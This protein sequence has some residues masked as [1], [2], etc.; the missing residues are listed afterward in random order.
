[1]KTCHPHNAERVSTWSEDALLQNS[2]RAQKI[3][4]FLPKKRKYLPQ[5]SRTL[6]CPGTF[7]RRLLRLCFL[8]KMRNAKSNYVLLPFFLF[9][10]RW[11]LLLTLYSVHIFL[12]WIKMFSVKLG[13]SNHF[14]LLLVAAAVIVKTGITSIA[15]TKLVMVVITTV[16]WTD[17]EIHWTIAKQYIKAK[18]GLGSA[19]DKAYVAFLSPC[20]VRTQAQP[21]LAVYVRACVRADLRDQQY[22]VSHKRVML[23]QSWQFM[24]RE[25]KLWQFYTQQWIYDMS[26]KYWL[27]VRI[28]D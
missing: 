18:L 13:N 3:L 6:T 28:A 10:I 14:F 19:G 24:A 7:L 20:V 21:A 22:T 5:T 4:P 11:H 26:V 2:K 23:D 8:T 16:K 25:R 1:M 27:G 9:L 15:R 17:K 12:L